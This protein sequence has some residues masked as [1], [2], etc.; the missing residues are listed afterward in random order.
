MFGWLNFEDLANL[1]LQSQPLLISHSKLK[2][3]MLDN[4]DMNRVWQVIY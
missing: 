3:L 2:T 4:D 1:Y